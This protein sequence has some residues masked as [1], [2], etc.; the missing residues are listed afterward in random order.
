MEQIKNVVIY[1]VGKKFNKETNK[2]YLDFEEAKMGCSLK[3]CVYDE[4]GT[5]LYSPKRKF[6]ILPIIFLVIFIIINGVLVV[7]L[8]KNIDFI[9]QEYVTSSGSVIRYSKKDAIIVDDFQNVTISQDEVTVITKSCGEKVVPKY[10]VI[11][12]LGLII[13]PKNNNTKIIIDKDGFIHVYGIAT[14]IKL[15]CS[16]VK[17]GDKTIITS[18]GFIVDPNG[19][20]E[21]TINVTEKNIV[22]ESNNTHI[23]NLD[24]LDIEAPLGTILTFDGYVILPVDFSQT[25]VDKY[26]NIIMDKE[27]KIIAPDCKET[28]IHNYAILD[29]ARTLIYSKDTQLLPLIEE[30]GY[31]IAKEDETTTISKHGC[32]TIIPEGSIVLTNGTI[33]IGTS[34]Q[35]PYVKEDGSVFIPKNGKIITPECKEA[36]VPNDGSVAKDGTYIEDSAPSNPDEIKDLAL[37]YTEG[38]SLNVDKIYPGTTLPSKFF[39]VRNVGSGSVN[40]HILWTKVVND[41]KRQS[42]FVVSV[43]R[44]DKFI[45]KEVPAPAVDCRMLTS[46]LIKKGEVHSYEIIFKYLETGQ[47]QNIDQNKVFS[48]LIQVVT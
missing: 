40:Y 43:K 41:F 20:E 30:H 16:T 25:E 48:A 38:Q 3:F 29:P 2:Q 18:N 37:T 1:Y 47:N 21:A 23:V 19:K 31:V 32:I 5:V 10:S 39:E 17:V 6:V 13:I 33:I 27:A 36:V 14:V 7:Y 26:G 4:E 34:S 35:K 22:V 44:N 12:S 15:D 46:V 11:S 24:C 42:D 9:Y 45:I 8:F 28:K